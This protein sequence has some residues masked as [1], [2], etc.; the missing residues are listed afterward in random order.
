VDLL[1]GSFF[2]KYLAFI[3]ED[4]D[5]IGTLTEMK[6]TNPF[7]DSSPGQKRASSCCNSFFTPIMQLSSY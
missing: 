4:A 2:Q 3:E 6:I 1:I 5:F 7:Y